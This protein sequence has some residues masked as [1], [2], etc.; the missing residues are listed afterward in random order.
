VF[1][2]EQRRKTV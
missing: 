1:I 2:E